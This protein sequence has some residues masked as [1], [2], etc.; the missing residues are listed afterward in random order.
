MPIANFLT[1]SEAGSIENRLGI[2]TSNYKRFRPK[3]LFRATGMSP[4][5]IAQVMK[6]PRPNLYRDALPLNAKIAG[7]IIKLV[8]A[9]DYA[10]KL[11][12]EDL[13]ETKRWVISPNSFFFNDTPFEVIMRGDGLSVITWLRER[14]G[15][16]PGA[17]F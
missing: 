16:A 3:A 11:F 9:T 1:A 15:E 14:L 13:R 10:F 7:K 4:T 5:Q 17:A 2:L 12:K 6:I 8:I